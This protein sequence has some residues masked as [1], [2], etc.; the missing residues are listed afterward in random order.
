MVMTA[1]IPDIIP[2]SPDMALGRGWYPVE[3]F[4]GSQFRWASNDA[5]LLV[6]AL[7]PVRHALAFTLEPGP[8]VGLKPFK[9]QVKEG[10]KEL[11]SV[12]VRGKQPVRV[13]LPPAGPKVYRVVLHVEGGGR[14]I[15]NDARV[16]N[17]RVFDVAVERASRD[18]LSAEMELGTGW[19]PLEKHGDLAFRWVSNDANVTVRNA[20]GTA[21]LDLDLQSG[22]GL[23]NKPF[24]LHV[25]QKVGNEA[26]LVTDLEVSNRQRVDIPVPQGD[27][28]ELI[29]RVDSKGHKTPGDPRELNFR[30][31]QYA[32]TS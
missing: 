11:V 9:L 29:L 12:D 8:G 19:H 4:A 16:L 28:V 23:E 15:T 7:Q 25:L 30:A 21:H 26:K 18:V 17:F 2:D 3:T 1:V 24:V 10:G 5:E 31:F 14:T 20:D 22:P 13:E 32:G 27:R 6:V